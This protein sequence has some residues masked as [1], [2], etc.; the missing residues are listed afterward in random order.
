M[1]PGGCSSKEITA[2][3]LIHS[4]SRNAEHTVLGGQQAIARTA[5]E[6]LQVLF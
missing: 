6:K 4:V 3:R 2:P 5:T 1:E